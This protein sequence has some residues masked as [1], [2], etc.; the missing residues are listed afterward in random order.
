[1]FLTLFGKNNILN[2]A[3][4]KLILLAQQPLKRLMTL[5]LMT[6]TIPPGK[7]LRLGQDFQS[8][9]PDMLTK[10]SIAGLI[11]LLEKKDTTPDSLL[12]SGARDWVNLPDRMHFIADFF[13]CCQQVKELFDV[14]FTETQV[15]NMKNGLPP[16]GEL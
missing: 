2:A 13:R 11:S 4:E 14:P 12:E 10:L 9:Y 15:N 5:H 6:L 16:G 1:M 8:V 3:V 7:S